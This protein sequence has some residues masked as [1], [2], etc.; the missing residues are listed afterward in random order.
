MMKP[1]LFLLTLFL[2]QAGPT[3]QGQQSLPTG[4]IEGFVV[5]VGTTEG[6]SKARVTLSIFQGSG[7]AQGVTADSEGKF[8]IRNLPAGQYRL[9]ATRDAYVTGSY[10]QRGPNGSGT[11]I[12]LSDRQQLKEI[13]IGMTPSGAIA[14]RVP[15]PGR[16]TFPVPGLDT[17]AAGLGV[18][19]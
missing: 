10:G 3:Q 4:S 7:T 15:L 9:T 17:G 1:T 16:D 12:T 2:A 14:G 5:K 19:D 18:A 13:R 11:T 8:V 6:V